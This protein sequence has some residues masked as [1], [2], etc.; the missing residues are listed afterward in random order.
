M[1]QNVY[2]ENISDYNY[3]YLLPIY[4]QIETKDSYVEYNRLCQKYRRKMNLYLDDT[5]GQYESSPILVEFVNI[6]PN[7]PKLVDYLTYDGDFNVIPNNLN[8]KTTA[9]E[10]QLCQMYAY[11]YINLNNEERI[12]LLQRCREIFDKDWSNIPFWT[13]KKLL[14]VSTPNECDLNVGE[15]TRISDMFR[16]N[17]L[18]KQPLTV[19]GSIEQA[20]KRFRDIF[21]HRYE[22]DLLLPTKVITVIN[23]GNKMATDQ[24]MS[25]LKAIATDD[26]HLRYRFFQERHCLKIRPNYHGVMCSDNRIYVYQLQHLYEKMTQT[27]WLMDNTGFQLVTEQ[28]AKYVDP[29]TNIVYS[30]LLKEGKM[31]STDVFESIEGR[32]EFDV[33]QLTPKQYESICK[34]MNKW[35]FMKFESTKQYIL[36]RT[37][38]FLI[39]VGIIRESNLGEEFKNAAVQK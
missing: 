15:K 30:L 26:N 31:A 1:D 37:G 34:R 19:C 16:Q 39:F 14:Q 3:V 17:L 27:I 18:L 21:I 28:C 4:T 24:S 9:V 11:T 29:I 36:S 32:N 13:N 6:T 8:F 20:I 10:Y 22:Y 25:T 38:S 35:D 33:T 5:G 7:A 12:L 23:L 2:L